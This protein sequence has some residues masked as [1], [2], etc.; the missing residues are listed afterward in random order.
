MHRF[1][2]S[3]P[4]PLPGETLGNLWRCFWLSQL[5][6]RVLRIASRDADAAEHH[7]R[8]G[9][10]PQ[11][12]PQGRE[13]PGPNVSR[14]QVKEPSSKLNPFLSCSLQLL[15]LYNLN[16]AHSLP[17]LDKKKKG[18]NVKWLLSALI[19]GDWVICR[20]LAVSHIYIWFEP[21]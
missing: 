18:P 13:L 17:L 3:P 19:S 2:P 21:R 15:L 4:R 8:R 7:S 14:A 16:L 6:G 10:A 11:P 20:I 5:E 12:P 9:T 1:C